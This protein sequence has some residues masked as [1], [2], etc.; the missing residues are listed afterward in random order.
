VSDVIQHLQKQGY[1]LQNIGVI[2][3]FNVHARALR[4]HLT[5]NF[6]GLDAK[7]VGTIHTFQG[8]EKK[9]IILSTKVCRS[10]DNVNWLNKRVNLLNVAVSRA[11][12]LFILVGN[13]YRL[14]KGKL[15]PQ[16]VEHIREHGDIL[17]YKSEAEI[18][19]PQPGATL[20]YDCD[21][22]KVFR[23]AL[24]QAEEELAIVT[25]WIRGNESNRFVNDIVSALEKGVKVR[26]IYGNKSS[27][28]NDGNDAQL[29]KDLEK[30]FSQ[31]PGS[32]ISCLGKKIHIESRGTNE[33]ILV[34]DTKFAVLGSWNWLSHPYRKQCSRLSINSKVQIRRETSIQLSDSLSIEE[35]R[36]RIFQLITQ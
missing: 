36:A 34:C 4:E 9:V 28:E 23:E 13:L 22:L 14:E 27:E 25:P 17:D 6:S 35:I 12:E 7:S 30:L 21:H 5:Q 26:L 31:Y 32:H 19:Q 11:K 1:S 8:S 33:K 24:E 29:E 15:T 3:P 16:L 2:S 18:P 10:Q 20:V